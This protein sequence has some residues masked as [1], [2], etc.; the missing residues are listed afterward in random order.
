[1]RDGWLLAHP[2]TCLLVAAAVVSTSLIVV[3]VV[4]SSKLVWFAC[5]WMWLVVGFGYEYG[6]VCGCGICYENTKRG[7]GFSVELVY[8][9]ECGKCIR[10]FDFWEYEFGYWL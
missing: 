3:F 8:G 10:D 7:C 6:Y 4:L 2:L 5:L 9:Y 1:M